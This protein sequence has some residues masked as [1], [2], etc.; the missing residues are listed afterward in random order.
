MTDRRLRAKLRFWAA[1]CLPILASFDARIAGAEGP[2]ERSQL[3]EHSWTV[4]NES[5]RQIIHALLQTRDGYLWIGTNSG[6]IRFD[7]VRFTDFPAA[8]TPGMSQGRT[9]IRAMWED[10]RGGV[11]AGTDVGV[12]HYN[13]TRFSTLT[14]R[15]GLPSNAIIR[16][17]GDETGA[18][19]IYT[20]KGVCRWKDGMLKAVHPERDK[21]CSGPLIT[22]FPSDGPDILLLGV[23]R[24]CGAGLERFAYGHWRDFPLPYQGK[25]HEYFEIRSI[26]EDS[27]R[28]VWYS[29]VSEPTTYYEVSGA[30]SLL[31][32]RGLPA[33]S[34]VSFQD[35]DGFLWISDHEA[36]THA[37]RRECDIRCRR[38]E[39]LT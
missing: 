36:H 39:R 4:G 29:L 8:K 11:W 22:D 25:R 14:K 28:R 10:S 26:W 20:R 3:L 23:W 13:G 38:Y 31:T 27:L 15:E 30:N 33:N 7:G 9:A 1:V 24:A 17:D 37:G 18:V 2:S 19:W 5:R 35:R 21:N 6:L 12:T 32:Y 16:I 34:F